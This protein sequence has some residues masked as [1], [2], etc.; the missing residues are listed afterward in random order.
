MH[1]IITNIRPPFSKY[2]QILYIFAQIFKYFA[3]FD[4]FCPFSEKSHIGPDSYS[5]DVTNVEVC[6]FTEYQKKKK[7]KHT[8]KNMKPY[9]SFK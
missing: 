2:F 6:G 9:F 4:L 7:S 5:H 8:E 1:A 3:L